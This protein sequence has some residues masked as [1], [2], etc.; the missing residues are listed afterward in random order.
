MK[1]DSATTAVQ[2]PICTECIHTPTSTPHTASY[3]SPLFQS[4][5]SLCQLGHCYYH[6]NHGNILTAHRSTSLHALTISHFRPDCSKV[7]CHLTAVSSLNQLFFFFEFDLFLR[8]LMDSTQ[9][10]EYMQ[11]NFLCNLIWPSPSRAPS[12]LHNLVSTFPVCSP[13]FSLSAFCRMQFCCS[14]PN[15]FTEHAVN[16]GEFA[17]HTEEEHALWSWQAGTFTLHVL[18]TLFC[19]PMVGKY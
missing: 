10:W 19:L 5:S 1:H 9:R 16:T 3:S 17:F 13:V 11:K 18:L 4:P 15:K 14:A 12:V 8:F 6:L 7:K 2:N